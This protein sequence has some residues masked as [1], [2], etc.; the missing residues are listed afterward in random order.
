MVEFSKKILPCVVNKKV[1]AYGEN[2]KGRSKVQKQMCLHICTIK[3]QCPLCGSIS[4]NKKNRS[5]L[6][7]RLRKNGKKHVATANKPCA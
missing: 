2:K 5:G 1:I 6:N 4:L 7:Y 3:S